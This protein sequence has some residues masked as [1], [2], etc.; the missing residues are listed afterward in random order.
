MAPTFITFLYLQVDTNNPDKKVRK[1]IKKSHTVE[2]NLKNLNVSK[3]DLEFDVD[4]LF[5]KTSS[6]FDGASGGRQFLSTLEVAD[7]TGELLLD[8]EV[9]N[10][11]NKCVIL[12]YPI[13]CEI[14]LS[15]A[16][17]KYYLYFF[18]NTS[19]F[20]LLFILIEQTQYF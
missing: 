2:K 5:K 9:R 16:P 13:I 4:P 19:F 7:E 10:I 1:R 12:R 15:C 6:Q 18:S 20:F 8:S 11:N 3:F 14:P 17:N